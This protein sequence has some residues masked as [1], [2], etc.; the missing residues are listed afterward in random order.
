MEDFKTW[1]TIVRDSFAIIG[2]GFAFWRI[3]VM[4]HTFFSDHDR[5][6]RLSALDMIKFWTKSLTQK[7]SL[8]RKLVESFSDDQ[9]QALSNQISF[10]IDANK[11]DLLIEY[12]GKENIVES[13]NLIKLNEGQSSILRWEIISYLNQLET[14]LIAWKHNIADKEILEEEFNY[15]YKPEKGHTLIEKFRIATGI[16]SYPGIK[17]FVD[18]LKKESEKKTKK[19]KKKI[20]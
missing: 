11:R 10:N 17:E 12:F 5:S 7:S 18:S 19:G 4:R 15:L 2:I 6:R 8:A 1:L 16:D 9:C 14:V 20:K 3:Y 13:N